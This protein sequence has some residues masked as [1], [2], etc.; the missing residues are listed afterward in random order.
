MG[1]R[2]T[3]SFVLDDDPQPSVS[4]EKVPY[5]LKTSVVSQGAHFSS[6]WRSKPVKLLQG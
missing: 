5:T 1:T 3:I 4:L 6:K 2:H